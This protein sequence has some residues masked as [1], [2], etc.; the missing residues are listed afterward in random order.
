MKRI[1]IIEDN[2]IIQQLLCC[3]FDEDEFIV[4]R[5]TDTINLIDRINDF[6]PDLIITDIMLPNETQESLINNLKEIHLPI[7]VLSS[8]DHEEV[9]SFAK[10]IG[11]IGYFCKHSDLSEMFEFTRDF[12]NLQEKKEFNEID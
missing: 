5:L 3:W 10:K 1:S 4:L 11:A 8:L 6:K 9:S 7:I 2:K 12:F